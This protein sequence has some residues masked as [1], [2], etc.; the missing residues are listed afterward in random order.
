MSES[1]FDKLIVTVAPTGSGQQWM[2]SPYLPIT[3]EQIAEEAVKAYEEGASVVHVHARDPDTKAPSPDVSLYKRIVELIRDRCDMVIQ[4]TSSGGGPY[5]VTLE[6]RMRLIVETRPEFASLNV[7]TMTFGE[8]VFLNPPEFVRKLARTMLELGVK[9]EV[10]CYDV[11][12]LDLMKILMDEEL[13][14]PPVRASLVLGVRGGVPA[15]VENLVHMVKQIPPGVRWN[16]IVVGRH[17]FPLLTVGMLMGGDV[18]VGM[19]DN[20]YL[21]KGVLAKSNAELVSKIVR[22]AKEFGR[23]IATPSEAREILGISA[24]A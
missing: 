21:G 5:G 8:G 11:G 19:E 9:P 10:E 7:G 4:I 23:E 17:Q 6:Q 13:V 22:I 3:P 24:K 18:R 15:T 16:T 14:K 2:K 20:I 1:V 12:H